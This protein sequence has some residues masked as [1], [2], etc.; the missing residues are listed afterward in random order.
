MIFEKCASPAL[1]SIS[2]LSTTTR[3]HL[4]FGSTGI[5]AN[6]ATI[7]S[8][9]PSPSSESQIIPDSPAIR[10][11]DKPCSAESMSKT[12]TGNE[13][14]KCIGYRNVEKIIPLFKNT[15]L[16]NFHI[17]KLDREPILDLG[18]IATIDKSKITTSPVPLPPRF[19]D[20]MHMD[21]GYGCNAGLQG[22]KY[23][24]F[25]VDRATRYKFI[26]PLKSLQD[27]IIPAINLLITDM[28]FYPKKLIADFD[29]K[30][31]G[32]SIRNKLAEN[33]TKIEAA[34]PKHQ[35]HNGLVERNW[36]TIVRMVRSWLTS[37][38]LPS[39]FWFYA[40]KR[41]VEVSN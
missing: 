41:V 26:Y 16:D 6:T 21:I 10:P 2:N 29:Q 8:P 11:V 28:G 13:N 5:T 18:E 36:R 24:L 22:I 19:G 14:R 31:I 20:V 32:I 1:Q 37:S 40:I 39:S 35:H 7:L 3:H 38:L 34:P 25:I 4:G 9:P 33:G 30:L 17:S 15:F 12:F 27:D 23:A